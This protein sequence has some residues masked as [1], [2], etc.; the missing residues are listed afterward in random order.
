MLLH[1]LPR[2]VATAIRL[3]GLALITWSVLV[4]R[5]APDTSG[6][7]LVVSVGLVVAVIAFLA[8]AARPDRERGAS[9]DLY[10]LAAAGGVLV[11]ASPSSAASA[12]V[13]VAV[14][15]AGVRAELAR[16]AP[17]VAVGVLALA[18]SV[19]VYNGSALAVLAYALGF[20]ASA[21]AA[22]N[23][24]QS[25]L[26]ADQAELLLAQA[27][28]SQEEQLRAARLEESTRIARDVHDVLAHSLSALTIQL[29]ATG[30]LVE[31]GADADLVL[32]RIRRAHELAR[33][34]LRETRYAV[35]A[36]RGDPLPAA[37][38]LEALVADYRASA[39]EPIELVIAG[40]P[41]RLAGPAGQVVVRV[42]QE[43]L[44]NV[45]KHAPG[46]A[47]TV[48][49]HAGGSGEDIVLRVEDRSPVPVP[50]PLTHTGGG[51]GLTGMRE[52]A[53]SLGGTLDAEPTAGGWRVELRL[54]AAG[55]AA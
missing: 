44:T 3:I 9:P 10:V 12:F 20:A 14:A 15:T 17:L 8:W 48:T 32:T 1:Q 23:S 18:L 34:G 26:R 30:V 16:V 41:A 13:F 45:R 54:P 37:A 35:G 38:A 25:V 4:A 46:A 49:V 6:R 21:L 51:Y 50:A 36:L 39:D 43:A 7:G 47:V 2:R 22:S 42:V 55:A 11:G 27:Q 29:E 52:R 28:R 5:N 33:D 53:L 31:Q 19:L 24:R 40:D